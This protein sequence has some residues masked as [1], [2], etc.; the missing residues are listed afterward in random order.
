MRHPLDNSLDASSSAL[1]RKAPWWNIVWYLLHNSLH[2]SS[3]I[4]IDP[5]KT[6]PLISAL[7][8]DTCQQNNNRRDNYLS[9]ISF[10]RHNKPLILIREDS[11][12][13]A[14]AIS[15]W[16][17]SSV[18][19]TRTSLIF[20]RRSHF[21]EDVNRTR[22]PLISVRKEGS[23]NNLINSKKKNSRLILTAKWLQERKKKSEKRNLSVK[24]NKETNN[25]TDKNKRSKKT[26]ITQPLFEGKALG[27][28][29]CICPKFR[30]STFLV[31]QSGHHTGL[32]IFA[33][34]FFYCTLILDWVRR[35]SHLIY[36]FKISLK[37]NG[38]F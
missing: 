36:F 8:N 23:V 3:E 1:F 25:K 2:H 5:P 18:R 34:V 33:P 26:K 10:S 32:K 4:W 7:H 37:T 30:F 14:V 12:V 29:L 35:I 27:T 20:Y 6:F 13:T 21:G 19:E 28:R 38:S 22:K 17:F 15:S 24:T 11:A 31:F 16:Q 9:P